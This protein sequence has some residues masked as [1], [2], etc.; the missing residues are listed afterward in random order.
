MPPPPV[1][2]HTEE[3]EQLAGLQ[4]LEVLDGE[5]LQHFEQH[6][7]HCARCRMMVRLDREALALAAPEM[8]PSPDF[9]ARLLERAAQELAEPVEPVRE[10]VAP[11][12]PNVVPFRRRAP[13]ASVLAAVLVLGL[14]TAG[15]YAYEN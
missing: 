13:W 9:K 2:D 7:A 6:A 12:A 11:Q 15:G 1:D 10:D 3:F 8:E 5:D 4:A 14:V